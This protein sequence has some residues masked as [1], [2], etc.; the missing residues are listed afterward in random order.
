M[1]RPGGPALLAVSLPSGGRLRAAPRA[2]VLIPSDLHVNE[3]IGRASRAA[4]GALAE[5]ANGRRALCL[6]RGGAR[7]ARA[8]EPAVG[9]SRRAA[10]RPPPALLGRH[11][12]AAW[13]G[14]PS[15]RGPEAGRARGG[16]GWRGDV[17]PACSVAAPAAP[18]GA[19]PSPSVK[20]PQTPLLHR[21]WVQKPWEKA[22]GALRSSA[23]ARAQGR[24][25][26]SLPAAPAVAAAAGTAG[27][28]RRPGRE[29][30]RC[31][32]G[33]RNRLGPSTHN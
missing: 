23:G 14:R 30:G 5:R 6:R 26:P 18:S 29:R 8:A 13:A 25:C 27:R 10:R 22:G 28:R 33:A 32:P 31:E 1:A 9:V 21:L 17:P 16:G 4:A 15:R 3:P 20:P 24:R 7:G 2:A 11:G 19:R 12:P